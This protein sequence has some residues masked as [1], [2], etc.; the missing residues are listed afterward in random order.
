MKPR[1]PHGI[2][3]SVGG[4][5]EQPDKRLTILLAAEKLFALNGYHG[6]SIRDIS[7]EAGVPLALVGYY[8]GAKHELYHAIFE[9][10]HPM[11]QQRLSGLAAVIAGADK[12]DRLDRILDAF[13][14]PV[15]ALHQHPD[16][17]YYA[18]MAA[19]DLA[20]PS[21]E[22]E[23]VHREFFD[24]MAHA[25]IDALCNLHPSA[26]RGQVAWCYQF[27]LGALL[28]FMTDQRVERLSGGENRAA[29]PTAQATLLNFVAAGFRA[30]LDKPAAAPSKR[31]T[32]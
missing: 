10:W 9:S 3:R 11:I 26:T 14:G 7:A 1:P 20:A 30:V 27:M 8:F 22:A 16:G 15:L 12:S 25:F 5:T 17:R 13:I 19:R 24:P 23:Q 2:V 28:H 29:D 18:L 6:V 4:P 31:R 21:P 32:R